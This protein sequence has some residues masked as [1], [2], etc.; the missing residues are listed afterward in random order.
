MNYSVFNKNEGNKRIDMAKEL[1]TFLPI[2]PSLYPSVI[3]I[4]QGGMGNKNFSKLLY[5]FLKRLPRK[6][7]DEKHTYVML[8][9]RT[10]IRPH[11]S[12]L[13]TQSSLLLLKSKL[14]LPSI[15]CSSQSI[16]NSCF[17]FCI[18]IIS[19]PDSN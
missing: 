11:A 6:G 17:H 14:P 18:L 16:N 8:R 15:A 12:S 2:Y 13:P 7:R 5:L 4:K 10:K 19:F 1:F 9:H 3:L